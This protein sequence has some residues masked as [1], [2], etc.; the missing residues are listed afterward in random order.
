MKNLF[1]SAASLCILVAGQA[2]AGIGW[3]TNAQGGWV[4]ADAIQAGQESNGTPLY[5]CTATYNSG[6]HP[7]KVRA[8]FGGCNIGYGGKEITLRNYSVLTGNGWWAPATFGAIPYNAV[9]AGSEANQE[10]LFICRAK[11]FGGVHPGKI[12]QGFAGCNIAYGSNEHVVPA[13]DVLVNQ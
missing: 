1:L 11:L 3:N 2:V 7:G 13:Y 6:N 5:S 9:Q 10:P 8:A 12:R 4:P